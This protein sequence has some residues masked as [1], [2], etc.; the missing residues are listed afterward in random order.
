MS[1]I[2]HIGFYVND[3]L[4]SVNFFIDIGFEI[5][6]NKEEDWGNDLGKISIIKLKDVNGNVLEIL[7]SSKNNIPTSS[8]IALS[9]NNIE[10]VCTNLSSKGIEFLVNCRKSPDG[11]VLVAFCKD[12][13]GIIVELVEQIEQQ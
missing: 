2:R 10:K 13:N 8:H 5:C 1:T 11:S 12:P 6:Y 4:S 3:L 9:I 7:Q